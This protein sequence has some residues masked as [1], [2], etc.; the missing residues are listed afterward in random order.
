MAFPEERDRAIIRRAEQV[1]GLAIDLCEW[2][3]GFNSRRRQLDLL[4]I[5]ESD[6]FEVLQLRRRAGSLYKSA[7]VPVAAAVY[8]P[9]QVGKSLFVGQL[10]RPHSDSYSPLGR[11]EQSGEPAYYRH[12]S[13]D[14]DLN[15]QSGSNEATAL[16][17]RFTTKDRIADSV[18]P[19]YPVMVKALT[20][21]EWLCVLARGFHGECVT[22]EQS[23]QQSTLEELFEQLGCEYGGQEVDRKWRMD[24]LDTFSY[25]RNVDRRGFA[26]REAIL[27]GLLSRYPLREEG[28][29]AAA[30]ALFW[31]N[32]K[33]LTGLFMRIN[34]F[35]ARIA[36]DNP[37]P[38]IFTHWAG[39]RFLLDS[40][41]QKV[42]ERP[43]SKCFTRV[44]WADFHLVQRGNYY[45]LEY[46]PGSRNGGL[47]QETIQAGML[48]LVIPIL[49]HRLNDDWQK[50]IAQ[51]D[52]LDIPGMRA[53]RQGP[54]EGKRASADTLDE[55]MEIVKRGKVAYLF[56][57]YTEEL[58]IQ[59]LLL[60]LRGGNLE[61]QASMKANV[62]RWGHARYGQKTWPQRVRDT[63]PALFVGMTGIDEEFRNR[64]EGVINRG[65][66]D[67]RLGQLVDVL[68]SVMTDFGAREQAFTNVYPI[69]YPGTWD[70]DAAQRKGEE[71][72]WLRAG[73][74]F[75]ESDMVKRFVQSPH[76][77]WEAAQRDDDGGLSLI[78]AGIRTVTKA[79]DKQEQ[80]HREIVEVE[81][82]LLQLARAWIV[83]PDANIDRE[84]R[85]KAAGRVLE[86][87]MEHEDMV[88]H[89]VYALRQSL[90]VHE[91][92]ELSLAD[93]ADLG[94][95]H[96]GE[97]LVRQL[98]ALLHE[99]ATTSVP[100]R[101]EQYI[102]ANHTGSPWLAPTDF[103]AF[104]R[105][106]S[107]YLLT[108]N[109]SAELCKQLSPVVN[110]KIKDEA[111]KRRARRKYVR[112][113]LN[114]FLI[115]PGPGQTPLQPPSKVDQAAASDQPPAESQESL[116]RFGLMG[117]FL[118][119][120]IHRLPQALALGAGE[121]VQI[122]PGNNELISILE[123]FEK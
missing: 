23:W 31:G 82:R 118:D 12:L 27:N 51:M 32:W 120:W 22:P 59:T 37:D 41:R 61:V 44:E 87:L 119:R 13:F 84:K 112:I 1:E 9:S 53:G 52:F 122:P 25:M 123:P 20:R 28:Y 73:R 8:G 109:V 103:N 46:R 78:S 15:P 71:Q 101:W 77:R 11:D 63:L 45:V 83:D 113:I 39:V 111:A 16:V 50:V 47:D 92:D 19:E 56:E 58:Q 54:E 74:A 81:N 99:W 68:G 55:Q 121:H 79:D 2:L 29:I 117:G 69:R 90:A 33:S 96:H 70:T 75:L 62:D 14:N 86:W 49:P 85:I 98:K 34:A 5:A 114:D 42:H 91:G 100:K 57:R 97:T 102:V 76:Q 64:E 88:Y 72:K 17:T 107:D 48:E 67:T 38:A 18:A 24:I 89:R 80:L 21:M 26:A 93:V 30:A 35:L 95:V 10:L 66:Y 105:F 104:V 108:E 43:T 115:N 40:Q 3:S 65:L 94:R 60:L 110:L 6:V 4:P 36:L 116:K 7:R 106:L